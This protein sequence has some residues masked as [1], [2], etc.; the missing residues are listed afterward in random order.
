MDTKN[1]QFLIEMLGKLDDTQ[2]KTGTDI[3]AWREEIAAWKEKMDAETRAIQ[4]KSEMT[5]AETKAIVER[6]AAMREKRLK[7][8][9]NAWQDETLACQEM[10]AR[11]IEKTPTSPDKKPEAAQKAEAPAENATVMPVEEP[12]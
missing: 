5:K 1:I 2:A 10:E 4:A 12:K 7:A 3:K 8:N 9:M 11:L 6:T